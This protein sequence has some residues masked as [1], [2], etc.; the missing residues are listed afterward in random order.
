MRATV[1][2][3]GSISSRHQS[4]DRVPISASGRCRVSDEF[5]CDLGPK[6]E[7]L[8]ES[9]HPVDTTVAHITTCADGRAPEDAARE[10][11]QDYFE[12][13]PGR[14]QVDVEVVE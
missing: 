13:N 14:T 1:W 3:T 4:F 7:V 10:A 6:G 2:L 8:V 5:V 9:H 11:A 12:R